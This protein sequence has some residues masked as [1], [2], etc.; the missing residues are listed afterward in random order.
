MPQPKLV[1]IVRLARLWIAGG[2]RMHGLCRNC[3]WR[4]IKHLFTRRLYSMGPIENKHLDAD[5]PLAIL[6]PITS[7]SV[8]G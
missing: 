6:V 8:T 3:I 7:L 5:Y 4:A 2:V 1:E